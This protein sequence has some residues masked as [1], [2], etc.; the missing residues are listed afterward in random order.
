MI[1]NDFPI[2]GE[3]LRGSCEENGNRKKA[4]KRLAAEEN[5]RKCGRWEQSKER[6]RKTKRE[7]VGS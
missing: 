1:G 5:E 3:P 6:G 4:I 7:E 2:F